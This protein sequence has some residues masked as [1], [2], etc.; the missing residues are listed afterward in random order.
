MVG[1]LKEHIIEFQF[2]N[3]CA[4][5]FKKKAVIAAYK[6][7]KIHLGNLK[8]LLILLELPLCVTTNVRSPK[9]K[10]NRIELMSA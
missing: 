9:T 1:Y 3:T 5:F 6:Y 10:N 2:N 7:D 8:E 4:L